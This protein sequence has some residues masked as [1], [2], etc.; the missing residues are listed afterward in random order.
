D[1]HRCPR[2]GAANDD[3]REIAGRGRVSAA[4]H[5]VLS[6][7]EIEQ[8]SAGLVVPFPY[9]VDN[10]AGRDAIALQQFGIEIDLVLAG[11]AADGRDIGNAR[12]REQMIAQIPVL[13]RA[14]LRQAVLSG[15]IDYGVL[16]YPAEAGGVRSQF[17]L[18]AFGKFAGYAGQTFRG[19]RAGQI[20]ISVVIEDDVDVGISEI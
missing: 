5:H 2:F 1:P 8:A 10:L 20:E 3:V 6:A 9:R 12:N 18:Y 14:Q 17:R 19:P 11:V 4:A 16:E 7:A 13:I 15:L